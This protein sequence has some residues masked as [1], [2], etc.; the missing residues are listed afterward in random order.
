MDDNTTINRRDCLRW[1]DTG[2]DHRLA[3]AG[4]GNIEGISP[5]S[6]WLQSGLVIKD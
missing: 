6:E 3:A 5:E 2:S 4:Y 1:H